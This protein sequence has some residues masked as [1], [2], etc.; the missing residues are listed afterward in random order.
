MKRPIEPL[1]SMTCLV[2]SV[3][4]QSVPMKCM[5]HLQ[6]CMK[7]PTVSRRMMTAMRKLNNFD[8]SEAPANSLD[9]SSLE[10]LVGRP[11]ILSE[12]DRKVRNDR[13]KLHSLAM[14]PWLTLGIKRFGQALP[15]KYNSQPK[16]VDKERGRSIFFG[17]KVWLISWT[18]VSS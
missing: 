8:G 12:S 1:V 18:I 5:K 4:P 13:M 3:P 15:T 11:S 9:G 14:K 17:Y 7:P 6:N 16:N 10:G 2:R